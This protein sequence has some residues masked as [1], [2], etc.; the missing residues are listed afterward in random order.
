[1]AEWPR[2]SPPDVALRGACPRCGRGRLFRGLLTIVDRCAVC[3]LD[4][5]GNDAGDGPAVFVILGLGA[6]VM[7]LVFWVEFRFEPPWWLHVLIWGPLT[8]G[9][10]VW[11]LRVLKA[12][13]IAQQYTHRSTALDDE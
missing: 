10:A 5:R 7:I 6:I 13:L 4:L 3:D 9:L 2:Q 11:F 12:L 8:F 1:M